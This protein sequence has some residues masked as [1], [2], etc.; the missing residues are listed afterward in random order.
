MKK[1]WMFLFDVCLQSWNLQV[2]TDHSPK[3]IYI[4]DMLMKELPLLLECFHIHK[5]SQ[6][7]NNFDPHLIT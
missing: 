2:D 4:A 6:W 3:N 7:Q 1:A 5:D